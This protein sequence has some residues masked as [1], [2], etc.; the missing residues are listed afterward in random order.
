MLVDIVRKDVKHL[1][2]RV[3]YDS[4]RDEFRLHV[5]APKSCLRVSDAKIQEFI[6]SK[7]DWIQKRVQE[8]RQRPSEDLMSRQ[9]L[10]SESE[11]LTAYWAER[12]GVCVERV[13]L[14]KMKTR[15]GVCNTKT[16]II[17]FNSDLA[18][19]PLEVLEYI[20]VH[21]V[22]HLKVRPKRGEGPHSSRFWENVAQ[23][24]PNYKALKKMLH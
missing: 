9:R 21:E 4:A 11:K 6:R 20:C 16:H 1:R 19:Y 22:S 24:L 23:Y 5:S 7:D 15:W 3:E 2:M 17:T 10:L 12:M 8:I 13:R 14:R 18:K